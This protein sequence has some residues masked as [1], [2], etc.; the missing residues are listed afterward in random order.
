MQWVFRQ[1]LAAELRRWLQQVGTQ[2]F[3]QAGAEKEHLTANNAAKFSFFE[4]CLFIK[5]PKPRAI[6]ERLMVC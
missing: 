1:V 5:A 4:Y 3:N 6:P 2:T